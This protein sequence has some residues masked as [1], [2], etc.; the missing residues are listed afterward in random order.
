MAVVAGLG[1]RSGSALFPVV[2][3]ALA[4][5]GLCVGAYCTLPASFE[6]RKRRLTA[7]RSLTALSATGALPRI[8]RLDDLLIPGNTLKQSRAEA[9]GR[10]ARPLHRFLSAR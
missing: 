8:V 10:L 6:G 4:E 5:R 3:R 2:V 1:G 7:E 9:D